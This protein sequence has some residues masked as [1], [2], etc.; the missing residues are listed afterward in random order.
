MS[1]DLLRLQSVD[2]HRAGTGAIAVLTAVQHLKPHE[3]AAAI[4]CAFWAVCHRLNFSPS[5]V[6][7]VAVRI[8]AS[9]TDAK[10]GL[11]IQTELRA[12][13]RYAQEIIHGR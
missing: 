4:A 13:R 7:A 9:V 3:Q 1:I 5:T 6:H 11:G 2:P 12:L 10:R 8:M